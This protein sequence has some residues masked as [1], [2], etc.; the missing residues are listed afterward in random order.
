MPPFLAVQDLSKVYRAGHGRCWAHVQVLSRL[1]LLLT[2]GERVVITGGRGAGK[3]TLLH[4]L[5]GLRRP[6]AGSVRWDASRG[7]PYAL[8]ATPDDLARVPAQAVA[9]VDVPDESRLAA[10]WLDA[11]HR[12][13]AVG[14]S[15]LV[16]T[17]RPDA[18]A[19]LAHRILRLLDGSLHP[20][21]TGLPR[22]VAE[23]APGR[24]LSQSVFH[25]QDGWNGCD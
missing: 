10:D 25:G 14:R 18:V 3:T 12:R 21:T 20:E 5:T 9:L 23:G 19:P 13:H 8:C 4:C 15:W 17:A 24:P 1:S 6:D 16:L 7:V 22:R 2:R 11:L